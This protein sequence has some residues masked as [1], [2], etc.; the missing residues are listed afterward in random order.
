MRPLLVCAALAALMALGAVLWLG[1]PSHGGA[2]LDHGLEPAAAQGRPAAELARSGAPEE[3]QR[4]AVENEVLPVA[5]EPQPAAKSASE[6]ES[7]G[8]PVETTAELTVLVLGEE[9]GA[10]L[11]GVVLFDEPWP[12]QPVPEAFSKPAIVTDKL[13]RATFHLA[14]GGA[15]ICSLSQP[16]RKLV[17][18]LAPG[19]KR[20]DVLRLRC[21]ADLNFVLR[22]LDAGSGQPLAGA[23][24]DVQD[25][26]FPVTWVT[27]GIPVAIADER[28][29]AELRLPAWLALKGSVSCAGYGPV[30]VP[31]EGPH[32]DREHALEV[33]LA[34]GARLEGLVVDARGAPLADASETIK[35]RG[36]GPEDP[37][38]LMANLARPQDREKTGNTLA[39]G[40]YALGG[41][42]SGVDLVLELRHAGRLLVKED[43]LRLAAGEVRVRDFRVEA[44]GR[45]RGVVLDAAG[46]PVTRQPLWLV[47]GSE[48]KVLEYWLDEP[49][50]RAETDGEGRFSF[51]NV[52]PGAWLI[53]P[54][55]H[56]N[57]SPGSPFPLAQAVELPA[58][59]PEIEVT[60]NLPAGLYV[61]GR[62]VG[63]DG[64]PIAGSIVSAF[65]GTSIDAASDANGAFSLGPLPV[66]EVYITTFP[67]GGY[68]ASEFLRAQAGD[69]GIVIEFTR[70]ASISGTVVGAA[71]GAGLKAEILVTFRLKTG[72]DQFMV[73]GTD[74]SGAFRVSDLSAA[75]CVLVARTS[76]GL[77]SPP[78][79]V[80]LEPGE[81][82]SVDLRVAPGGRAHVLMPEGELLAR[83][84]VGG[85]VVEVL[86]ETMT[87]KTPTTTR[88]FP[89]G[90]FTVEL[91]DW[92]GAVL[93]TREATVAIGEVVEVDLR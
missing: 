79:A 41:L 16:E 29:L 89:P 83:I 54:A 85:D 17:V 44:P 20:A 56:E 78:R 91:M 49:A 53:G 65:A 60:L 47:P 28:G 74:N 18:E 37:N 68:V 6:R 46:A 2:Q 59:V 87:G 80:D 76:S 58:G 67:V 73:T 11:A 70:A 75:R 8:S 22:I 48:A 69:S 93:A 24:V 9:D 25:F 14:P 52:A 72:L 40:R 84:L 26:N 38:L 45:I 21:R 32:G 30:S 55:A 81:E 42:A 66:G 88:P 43:G 50:D 5:A 62:C 51:E 33:P 35:V 71:D 61:S 27:G 13:G 1:R 86:S 36:S 3:A 7:S 31:L 63:P 92:H 23:R 19:E 10:P 15:G 57:H 34:A 39:D 12:A 82:A 90:A 64:E 77:V 4:T